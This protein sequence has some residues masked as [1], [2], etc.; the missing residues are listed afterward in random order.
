MLNPQKIGYKPKEVEPYKDATVINIFCEGDKRESD[1]FTYFN[2]LSRKLII[3]IIKPDCDSSPEK[4][5]YK[6]EEIIKNDKNSKFDEIWFVIDK[7]SWEIKSI[8][9]LKNYCNQNKNFNMVVSNPCFEV[10]LYYHFYNTKPIESIDNWKNFLHEKIKGGFDSNI[11][12]MFIKNAIIFAKEN[13]S[14]TQEFPEEASTSL[15]ILGEKIYN[16]LSDYL[17]REMELNKNHLKIKEF[18]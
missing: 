4:L 8:K 5:K 6:C 2:E 11:H 3:Q 17:D 18:I 10:W 14:G 15:Y 12:P 7:D 1:Y 16:L 9:S 13:F